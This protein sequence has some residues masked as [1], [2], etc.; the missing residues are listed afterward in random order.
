[1]THK[2]PL[3]PR[4]FEGRRL[5]PEDE[6]ERPVSVAPTRADLAYLEWRQERDEGGSDEA[7]E[8]CIG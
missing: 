4:I 6:R 8:T 2:P 7:N 3:R 5:I 1:M